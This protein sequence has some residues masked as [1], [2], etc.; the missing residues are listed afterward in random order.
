VLLAEDNLVNRKVATRLIEKHGHEVV[1]VE[2]G[3]CALEAMEREPFDLV[4]LDV[5]MPRL[6][7]LETIA[8]IR[9]REGRD[10]PHVPVVALTAHAMKR[11]RERCLEAGMDDYLSK[12][13]RQEELSELLDRISLG[14]STRRPAAEVDDDVLDRVALLEAVGDDPQLAVELLSLFHAQIPALAAEIRGDLELG[15]LAA[16]ERRARAL[17]ERLE[18]FAA[19]AAVTVARRLE[20]AGRERD[21]TSATEAMV[22]LEFELQRLGNELGM[23]LRRAA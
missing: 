9:E 15:D 12:P 13:I 1:A 5:Q 6:D 23:L 19:R 11:D 21:R 2:D 16:T 14:R 20:A 4:L 22:A 18:T 3:L 17:A 10:G 7:G 8:R